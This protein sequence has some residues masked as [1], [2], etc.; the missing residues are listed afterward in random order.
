MIKIG[1]CTSIDNIDLIEK[2][3]YDYLETSLA[4]LA[5]MSETEYAAAL[6][7]V[8]NAHI[9]VE[10]CNG[11]LPA[12]VRV[13]GPDVSAQKIHDYLDHA[14]ARA[15]KLGVKTVVFGSAGAR[16]VPDG[17]D[18]AVAWRQISNFLRIAQTHAQAPVQ[19]LPDGGDAAADVGVGAGAVGDEHAPA[20]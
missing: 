13:T 6:A 18:F 1:I 9:K 5:A 17:F 14:F 4:G 20:L 15:S 7:K 11:M 16:N 12:E 19:V 3:G 2:I 10:A 8:H